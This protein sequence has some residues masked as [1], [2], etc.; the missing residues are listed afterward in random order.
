MW[1]S[2]MDCCFLFV[3]HE[4]ISSWKRFAKAVQLIELTT[5]FAGDIIFIKRKEICMVYK[6][7]L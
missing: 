2:G 1:K 5:Y 6:M 4:V 7:Y 3:C